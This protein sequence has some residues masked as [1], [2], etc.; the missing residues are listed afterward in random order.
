VK[1]VLVTGGTGFIGR[2][3][4]PLLVDRGYEVHATYRRAAGETGCHVKWHRADLLD[5]AEAKRLVEA[6]QPSHLL[7]FAWYA[8]PGSFWTSPEN[9]PWVEASLRLLRMFAAAG[10][11]RATMS[12]SCAEYDWAAGLLSEAATP[13]RPATFYGRCKRA[14]ESV[15]SGLAAE[16][17]F[18]FAWGRIFFVYGP[19]EHPDRLVP[20]IA[21]ALVRGEAAETS[22]GSQ[23]RDFL[24]SADVA[25]AFVA[26][27]D[28]D[29]EGAVNIASGTAVPVREIVTLIAQ[30]AGREDLVRWGALP[31]RP[32]DPP[33]IEA[34]VARL[35]DQ[36]GW[37]PA[38]PLEEGISQAVEWWTANA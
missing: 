13:L 36:V 9:V 30:A 2:N 37:R 3:A 23:R 18:S 38:I 20:Q 19:G 25:G 5:Q 24:H 16:Q 31:Q 33:V 21:R 4:L 11:Q 7:H 12:G 6:V 10:G 14:V 17:G 35:R 8:E 22:E 28:S 29:V 15:A 27:L 1:K 32:G 26:L 34:D